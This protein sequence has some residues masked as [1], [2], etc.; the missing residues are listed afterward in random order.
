MKSDK[1]WGIRDIVNTTETLEKLV[2][3]VYINIISKPINLY[4][5]K[6][7]LINLMTC[8]TVPEGHADS[9]CRRVDS[10]F[11]IRYDW[12]TDID[13]LPD[14]FIEIIE[15]IGG[16]LHDSVSS[17]ETAKKFQSTPQQLLERIKAIKL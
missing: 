1:I 16:A 5:I 11:C 3:E 7:A 2:H 13:H 6:T 4:L 17:P 8:L 14:N 10:F 15:D 12:E 9:N